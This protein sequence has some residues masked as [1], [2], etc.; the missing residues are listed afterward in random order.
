MIPKL[1]VPDEEFDRVLED[2]TDGEIEWIIFFYPS[3]P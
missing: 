2:D 1:G 3:H